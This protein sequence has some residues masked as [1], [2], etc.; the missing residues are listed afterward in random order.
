MYGYEIIQELEV[1][2]AGL[3]E[4]KEGTLYPLLHGLESEGSVI[5][6]WS[7]AKGSR[8]RKYYVVTKGGRALLKSK[9]AAWLEF[10]SAVDKIF[11]GKEVTSEGI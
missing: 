6:E 10:I 9:K 2:S 4:F 3:F 8:Q 11:S 1:L 5:S 7:G